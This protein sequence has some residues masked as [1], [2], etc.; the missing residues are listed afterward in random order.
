MRKAVAAAMALV[1]NQFVLGRT[2]DEAQ[3]KAKPFTK[4]GFR[5]SFDMLGEGARTAADAERNLVSYT[6]AIAAIGKG[7]KGREGL[8]LRDNISV[9][10]SAIHPRFEVFQAARCIPELIAA[11]LPLCEAAAR[12]GIGLTVDA[13]ESERLEMS[14]DVIEALAA[15][16]TL[17]GWDGLGLAVQAYQKRARSVIAWADALGAR[18]G[19]RMRSATLCPIRP[20]LPQLARGRR[21]AKG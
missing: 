10:L 19:R 14:L 15:A 13:E 11:M 4:A 6:A 7:Q 1:G 12:A 2:I 20:P 5:Y 18:T 9:K 17:G 8:T 16:P 3:R 21:A